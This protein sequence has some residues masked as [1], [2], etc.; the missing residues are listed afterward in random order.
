MA[1]RRSSTVPAAP[2]SVSSIVGRGDTRSNALRSA[3]PQPIAV[4]LGL[5]PGDVLLWTVTGEP[6]TLRITVARGDPKTAPPRS[7]ALR[8]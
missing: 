4:I 8:P 3:I 5:V 2:R 1:A 7:R 6:G